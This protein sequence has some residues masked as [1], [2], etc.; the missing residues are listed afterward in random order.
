MPIVAGPY[1]LT[2]VNPGGILTSRTDYHVLGPRESLFFLSYR[3]ETMA[4]TSLPDRAFATR[5]VDGGITFEPLAPMLPE[6]EHRRSVMPSTV[7]LPSGKL[8]SAL[9]RRG[10]PDG[11]QECWVDMTES[12]DDGVSWR[13]LSRVAATQD[14]HISHNG[15]PPSTVF[16]GDGRVAV[17]YGY[18]AEAR[19]G[20][21]ARVSVDEG[22][23]WGGE[24][25]L[26]DDGR[27]W[28]MGYPRSAVRPDG[29]IVSTYY[30]TTDTHREQ[31]IAAT[32]WDPDDDT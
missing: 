18:R 10:D 12:I 29:K 17:V 30:F 2:G 26:R 9:R 23:S 21:R 25:I 27:T 6:D 28:D 13:H 11:A 1:K 7:K 8:V 5:T 3:P 16:L 15:N 19:S 24:I 14:A 32:I 4:S 22:E 20:I 31:H